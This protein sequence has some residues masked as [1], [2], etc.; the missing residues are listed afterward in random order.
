[1]ANEH[2]HI[3][4]FYRKYRPQTFKD[5][6]G[7]DHIVRVLE[8]A[9]T[10]GKIAHAYLFSG[11]RG[12]GKTTVARILASELK[13]A[14]EDIFEIDAAS[15]RGIDDAR[16]LREAVRFLP[17]RSSKKVYIIDEVHMLTKEAFN[18]LLKTLEEP[19]EHVV[20]ILATTEPEKVLDT[21]ISRTQHFSFHKIP[22][23]LIV[24]EIKR[25]SDIEKMLIEEDAL[26]LIA[27]FADGA[28]R[29]AE[30]ILFQMH[31]LGKNKITENDARMILG[32]PPEKETK[33]LLISALK[34]DLS[35]ALKL[36]DT[37]L[38]EG[39]DPAMLA[40]LLLRTL[41]ALYIL[42]VDSKGDTLI[43]DEFSS[44]EIQEFR[45]LLSD[46]Q[47]TTLPELKKN[48]NPH[49]LQLELEKALTLILEVLRTPTDDFLPHLPLELALIKIAMSAKKQ[50]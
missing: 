28:L 8:N 30:N 39:A 19:P 43:K 46:L 18:A 50:E 34:R 35:A 44:A 23:P 49:A 32:A 12:T 22:I 5:V 36:L 17:L 48:E 42:A 38:N 4:V 31:S 21:I 1:M 20:F 47:T 40:K 26:K 10:R 24:N 14:P 3:P 45:A 25:I 33:N 41:R 9:L 7:Q 13:C 15:S 2:E 37:L 29:D 6:V 11:P 27:F 16:E